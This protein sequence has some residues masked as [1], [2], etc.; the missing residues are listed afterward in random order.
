MNIDKT[1]SSFSS[2]IISEELFS[3]LDFS[4]TQSGLKQCE[5]FITRTAGGV[6]YRTGTKFISE[7]KH[8]DKNTRL[9]PYSLRTG[10]G[11]CLEFGDKYIRFIKNG[12]YVLSGGVPYEVVTT[13]SEADLDKIKYI[14]SSKGLFLVHNN[15]KPMVLKRISDNN[16]SLTELNFNPDVL[17]PT[18]IMIAQQGYLSNDQTTY[19]RVDFSEW[20]YAVSFTDKDGHEGL[21]IESSAFTN[22]ISIALQSMK[23]GVECPTSDDK[24]NTIDKINFY[25]S[26]KGELAFLYSVSASD[27][28]TATTFSTSTTNGSTGRWQKK[29][30]TGTVTSGSGAYT[31]PTFN[32]FVL[33]D[34]NLAVD[35][36]RLTKSEFEGFSANDYPSA[37]AIWNQRLV[38][39]GTVSKPT[40]LWFS[41][42][43][44]YEDFTNTYLQASNESMELTLNSV[45][46]D[47]INDLVPFDDLFVFTQTK[48][49]RVVGSSATNMT[50][51]IESY[52]G[53][54][55]LSPHCSKKSV[56][57][58]E[59]SNN[60]IYNFAYVNDE[61]GYTGRN[62]TLL[63]RDL[64]DGYVLQDIS[65]KNTPMPI[66]YS[67][68]NDG[69][70]VEM[71]YE[72]EENVY[73][74][75][76]HSTDGKFLKVCCID[77][78]I[79]DKVYVIVER[80][81][82]KYVELFQKELLT[83]EGINESWYLDCATRVI[84][85]TDIYAWVNGDIALYTE[86]T[87]PSVGDLTITAEYDD[88]DEITDYDNVENTITVDE[89]VYTRDSSKD[90]PA[91][92]IDQVTGLTRF[93]G[94]KVSVMADGNFYE[95]MEVDNSGVLELEKDAANVLV[96]L[97]YRGI[98]ETL[99][100]EYHTDDDSYSVGI[101][102]RQVSI[103][104]NYKDTR[105]ICYGTDINKLY[106]IKPYTQSTY[107]RNI[108]LST[109]NLHVPLSDSY[110]IRRTVLIVQKT[111]FPVFIRNV[112]LE[113]NYG[114]KN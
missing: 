19:P 7:V 34:I 83:G 13:Y 48:V 114:E 18:S 93:A 85:A 56:L 4:K 77:E 8:S 32:G 100:F 3:R 96:G 15:Y 76:I 69:K 45:D 72:R 94:Q 97:S 1:Q 49:W 50:A 75:H 41:R 73:G 61:G 20:K 40:T 38:L 109:D 55:G 110:D 95:N 66:L 104:I 99:P 105:G 53:T 62:L 70:M 2:G 37:V 35:A 113:I 33:N 42:I 58:I 31:F 25:R 14:S 16:W 81:G 36:S 108:P 92:T 67:V 24:W 112:T 46:L 65:F 103:T 22:D 101:N 80:N 30:S 59:S 63:C 44:D 11:F 60:A 5:N 111:P 91:Q 10:L 68:R 9:I 51:Y 82:K 26:N 98:I 78:I 29:E 87:T 21:P 12:E 107:G 89:V 28:K 86:S 90:M 6:K 52:S 74:W 106:E 79:E 43:G 102:R 57:Y 71:T 88:G 47:V 17:Q 54:A 84:S 39:G 27:V 23:V 64:F